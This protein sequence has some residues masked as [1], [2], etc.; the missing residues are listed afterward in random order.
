MTAAHTLSIDSSRGWPMRARVYRAS[1]YTKPARRE[2]TPMGGRRFQ[3]SSFVAADLPSDGNGGG[4]LSKDPPPL[5]GAAFEDV[6]KV[7][8]G[9]RE[10][11][12]AGAGFRALSS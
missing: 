3:G 12:R 2:R 6:G 10:R 1:R 7:R 9:A 8:P 4:Y 11:R 5:T